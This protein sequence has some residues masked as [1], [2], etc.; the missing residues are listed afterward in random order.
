MPKDL[1]WGNVLTDA[2]RFNDDAELPCPVDQGGCGAAAGEECVEHCAS[3]EPGFIDWA[4]NEP[5]PDEYRD[6]MIADE[7]ENY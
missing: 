5:D 1:D 7:L 2:A 4:N 6:R 3:F